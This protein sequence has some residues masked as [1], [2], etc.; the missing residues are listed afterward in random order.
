MLK[1]FFFT[2]IG[3]YLCRT[4]FKN[5]W[6]DFIAISNFKCAISLSEQNS[7][8]NYVEICKSEKEISYYPRGIIHFGILIRNNLS[9]FQVKLILYVDGLHVLLGLALNRCWLGLF[10]LK[11]VFCIQFN[12]LHRHNIESVCI[13]KNAKNAMVYPQLWN[14]QIII[15]SEDRFKHDLTASKSGLSFQQTKSRETH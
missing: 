12:L 10:N 2:I 5:L 4:G 14:S 3:R 8:F 11:Y 7:R 1:T 6:I 9:W 15:L 13:Q